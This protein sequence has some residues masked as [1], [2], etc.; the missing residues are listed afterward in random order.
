[1]PRFPAF[2]RRH[3]EGIKAACEQLV[4]PVLEKSVSSSLA[5]S[6]ETFL[7]VAVSV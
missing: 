5:K 3:T 4:P 1:M 7:S 2:I 6:L